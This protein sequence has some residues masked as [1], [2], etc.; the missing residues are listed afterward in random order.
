MTIYYPQNRQ[1]IV[2]RVKTDVQNE[3]PESEP[4]LRNSYLSASCIGYGSG[5]YD[6]YINQKALQAEMFP[7]T[8][9]G[10]FAVRWASYKG[11]TLNPATQA[12]GYI[13][14]TGTIGIIIPAGTLFVSSDGIQY[15]TL[16]NT[17]ILPQVSSITTLTRSGSTAYAITAS[18]HH[19]VDGATPIISGAVQTEYNITAT[20]TVTSATT[21]NYTISGTPVTPATGTI[22]SSYTFASV[23]VSSITYGVDTNLDSGSELFIVTPIAGVNSSAFVQYD[24]VTGGTDQETD[25]IFRNRYLYAYQ[26][27]VSFFNVAELTIQ[28]R[29]ITGV[30]RVFVHEITPDIGQVTI[31]FTMSADNV[32]PTP[33]E[34]VIIKNKI[35]EIK[36][37]HVDPNDVIVSAPTPVPVTFNFSTL[38]PNTSTMQDA[39]KA[40]LEQMFKEVPEVGYNLSQDAYRSTIQQSVDPATGNFVTSFS[41]SSPSGNIVCATGQLATYVGCNFP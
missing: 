22:I 2:D 1:E 27:P 33:S 36:P 31:Y 32:I 40:N 20:I 19:L 39:I 8:A 14:I 38:V 37:A 16:Y 11:I 12:F 3:L 35:L 13:T 21:F 41:L 29:K 24:G 34:V 17:E 7:D 23:Q 6:L 18:D 26:H 5:F 4:F 10:E 15:Q 9:T 28:A 25:S 30:D